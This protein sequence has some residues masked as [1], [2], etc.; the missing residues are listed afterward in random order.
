MIS[1]LRGR[2]TQ[3]DNWLRSRR[4]IATSTL[5]CGLFAL[6]L[7]WD[8]ATDEH[9]PSHYLVG[10]MAIYVEQAQRIFHVRDAWDT[11]TPPGYPAFLAVLGN[12]ER[13]G[14]AQALL[15]ALTTMLTMFLARRMD[16]SPWPAL[17]AGILSALYFPFVFYAGLA[18]TETLF[19]FLLLVFVT[20][21]LHAADTGKRWVAAMAGVIL[22]LA[23]LVRP[24]LLTFLPFFV[25][26][27]WRD[28][29]AAILRWA[30]VVALAALAPMAMQTSY[31]LG[32]PAVV[33]SNG[34]VN[35]FLAN[36]DCQSVRSTVPGR[37]V[38][39][40]T[41]YTRTH[42]TRECLIDR[43]LLDEPWLY[44]A[45]LANVLKDP[46]RLWVT[47][48][49]LR[50]GLGLV[51]YRPWPNQPYWPGSSEYGDRLNWFSQAYFWILL[52]PALLHGLL[53]RKTLDV[54]CVESLAR[55]LAWMLLAS[56]GVAICVYNGNPRVRVSS[57]P[58]AIA[59]AASAIAS[60]ARVTWSRFVSRGSGGRA[61]NSV[62][63][64]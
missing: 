28:K 1:A 21:L 23:I 16:R 57:D 38:G 9:R 12:V 63:W 48:D 4:G 7:R 19:A 52:L 55:R 39:V 50:E 30:L 10:D 60:C 6:W 8:F 37:V 51:P 14:A 20:L 17:V 31:L 25:W 32:R 40:S 47:L 18:L 22:A 43:S 49:G 11:F 56:V 54:S 59:L 41:H 46:R 27:S 34:G 2:G 61:K 64:A 5:L 58:L 3:I 29:Q 15:G 24:S 26:L 33:A 13:L 53:R 44:R 45:G 35:F 62:F 42:Y 36:S